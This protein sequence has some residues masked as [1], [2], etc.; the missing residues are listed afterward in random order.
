MEY[1]DAYEELFASL[2]AYVAKYGTPPTRVM[3]SPYLYQWLRNLLVEE[4]QLQGRD[5]SQLDPTVLHT[6]YGDLQI[7]IDESLTD[8]EIIVE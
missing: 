4:A 1:F 5:V 7:V 8:W 3:L 6:D 2:S